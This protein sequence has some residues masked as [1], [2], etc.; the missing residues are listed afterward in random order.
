[1]NSVLSFV[2]V[3]VPLLVQY[4]RP[5]VFA[6]PCNHL[7]HLLLIAM[8]FQKAVDA[9]EYD[10]TQFLSYNELSDHQISGVNEKGL[11]FQLIVKARQEQCGGIRQNDEVEIDAAESGF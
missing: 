11:P 2:M 5:D 10:R 4:Y 8:H 6:K 7:H 1:M 9:R 3:S